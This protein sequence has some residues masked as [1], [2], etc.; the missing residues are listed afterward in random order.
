[1]SSVDAL[2]ASLFFVL[3]VAA[4][5]S[6]TVYTVKLTREQNYSMLYN[7]MISKEAIALFFL[8]LLAPASYFM[9]NDMFLSAGSLTFMAGCVAFAMDRLTLR[10]EKILRQR[11]YI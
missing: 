5:V 3:T 6:L 8:L 11:N 9:L 4:V 10:A 2:L 7:S 1:M